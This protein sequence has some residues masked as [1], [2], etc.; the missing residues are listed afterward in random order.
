[1]HG[2]KTSFVHKPIISNK[3]GQIMGVIN[4]Q[5]TDKSLS[6]QSGH[7]IFIFKWKILD[8]TLFATEKS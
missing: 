2:R 7:I 3:D 1:M 5:L 4:S 6:S 8:T